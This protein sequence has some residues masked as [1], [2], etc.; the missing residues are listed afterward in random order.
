MKVFQ[1]YLLDI[2]DEEN[3]RRLAEVLNWV[4]ERFPILE[5]K[6]AWNQPMFTDHGTFIIGFSVSK[7]HFAVS[8]EA[9]GIAVFSDEIAESGYSRGS[10]LFRIKWSEPVDYALLERIIQYNMADKADC[11]TF[12]RK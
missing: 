4:K 5:P 6:I 2:E 12:W 9:K 7:P 11:V 10:H 8:P 1:G 3:R